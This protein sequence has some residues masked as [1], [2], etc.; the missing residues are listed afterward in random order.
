MNL[1]VTNFR[2]T[3]KSSDLI[4][5]PIN[6]AEMKRTAVVVAGGSGTRMGT[7]VPKQFLLL[8]GRP[9]LMHT[10]EKFK[11]VDHIILVLPEQQLPL[12]NRLKAAH[13]F[14]LSHTVVHGGASRY[15][16]VK[17]GLTVAGTEGVIAVH[18][19]VRPL[20]S[21]DMID[22]CYREAAEHGTAIPVITVPESVRSKKEGGS[23]SEDRSRFLL[24][25]T[26]QCFRAEYVS[27][28]YDHGD[29]PRFT[30]DAS[31]LEAAGIPIHLVDGERWNIKI[32]FPED[33]AVAA[34]LL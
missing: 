21:P 22:R 24:V 34:A 32:T 29:D 9:V 5:D 33:L 10:L 17:N 31:V 2:E 8:S 25:Q 18:D 1:S 30:D 3:T 20:V 16:S 19:G 23:I 15:E 13:D 28:A 26:P 14:H 4:D 7:E 27:G 12:W 11:G 6:Y